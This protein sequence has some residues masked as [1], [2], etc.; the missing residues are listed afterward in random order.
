MDN[1]EVGRGDFGND[2]GNIVE[3]LLDQIEEAETNEALVPL[4][5]KLDQTISFPQSGAELSDWEDCAETI[6]AILG[7]IDP[8]KG[9]PV[10]VV[11]GLMNREAFAVGEETGFGVLLDRVSLEVYEALCSNVMRLALQRYEEAL[12]KINGESEM[13]ETEYAKI[14]DLHERWIGLSF[15]IGRS[16]AQRMLVS[17]YFQGKIGRRGD[18]NISRMLAHMDEGFRAERHKRVASVVQLPNELPVFTA[19]A[20][21]KSDT[22]NGL[23]AVALEFITTM[24]GDKTKRADSVREQL[25]D[26][27][28]NRGDPPR[29]GEGASLVWVDPM[30]D[31]ERIQAPSAQFREE[32]NARQM[33]RQTVQAEV[34]DRLIDQVLDKDVAYQPI[35]DIDEEVAQS[36]RELTGQLNFNPN[37]RKSLRRLRSL[38]QQDRSVSAYLLQCL[39]AR[40]LFE[41]LDRNALRQFLKNNRQ[42]L[43][44]DTN[45]EDASAVDHL[46]VKSL[47]DLLVMNV[48]PRNSGTAAI[49]ASVAQNIEGP[50]TLNGGLNALYARLQAIGFADRLI[51]LSESSHV[52]ESK[53]VEEEIDAFLQAL[54]RIADYNQLVLEMQEGDEAQDILDFVFQVGSFDRASLASGAQDSPETIRLIVSVEEFS[55]QCQ[56]Y[57]EKIRALLADLRTLVVGDDPIACERILT[58]GN[59]EQ[60]QVVVQSLIRSDSSEHPAV[61]AMMSGLNAP[62]VKALLASDANRI[63]EQVRDA[64]AEKRPDIFSAFPAEE[65]IQYEKRTEASEEIASHLDQWRSKALTMIE[66]HRQFIENNSNAGSIS[67]Q[68]DLELGGYVDDGDGAFLSGSELG[69]AG[70]WGAELQEA[71]LEKLALGEIPLVLLTDPTISSNDGVLDLRDLLENRDEYPVETSRLVIPLL[72]TLEGL[73]DSYQEKLEGHRLQWLEINRYMSSVTRFERGEKLGTT[74]IAMLS[75][76]SDVSDVRSI[77]IAQTRDNLEET[78]AELQLADGKRVLCMIT[79]N[80]A[81]EVIEDEANF[82]SRW[83]SQ[84]EFESWFYN[85]YLSWFQKKIIR[86]ITKA[87]VRTAGGEEQLQ[88][89]QIV[90]GNELKETI[91]I[92]QATRLAERLGYDLSEL[93]SVINAMEKAVDSRES[94]GKTGIAYIDNIPEQLVDELLPFLLRYIREEGAVTHLR[95]GYEPS[96]S[97]QRMAELLGFTDLTRHT[98]QD[99]GIGNGSAFQRPRKLIFRQPAFIAIEEEINNYFVKASGVGHN[100]YLRHSQ[101]F[102]RWITNEINPLLEKKLRLG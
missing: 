41:D 86:F 39:L 25:A 101:L 4:V 12:K 84:L 20:M 69:N 37:D 23:P 55:S 32:W 22:I 50:R 9:G 61:V 52:Q 65:G 99:I 16:L 42:I 30:V 80:G 43:Y 57:I 87:A 14:Q 92:E 75:S 67:F 100:F 79:A 64:Y 24:P 10:E 59:W 89:S 5:E 48:L 51:K 49:A 83:N 18:L 44:P 2:F 34:S 95:Q 96:D 8:G 88:A 94:G 31:D 45:M 15:A 98:R 38:A 28:D 17:N 93:L 26:L 7:K 70:F 27:K 47:I 46:A 54:E 102:D 71:D 56:S 58:E 29:V 36:V 72:K 3:A 40:S 21:I 60:I 33:N 77:Y 11:V 76:E 1:K 62:E 35:M 85:Q 6:L 66:E 91:T 13:T 68:S 78:E 82:I 74:E 97:S 53:F 81:I 90:E 63:L 19:I 73:L